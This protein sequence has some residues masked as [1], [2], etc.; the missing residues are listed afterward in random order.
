[1]DRQEGGR[2]T[3]INELGMEVAGGRRGDGSF[4]VYISGTAY[5]SRVVL[6]VLGSDSST[7]SLVFSYSRE[8]GFMIRTTASSLK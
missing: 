4:L 1:M 5:L 2:L 6:K 8:Y 7:H 3:T